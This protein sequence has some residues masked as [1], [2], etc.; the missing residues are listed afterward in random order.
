MRS[1]E[2]K[3]NK[4]LWFLLVIV[5]PLLFAASLTVIIFSLLGVNLID[6]GKNYAANVP[7]I[8]EWVEPTDVKERSREE[9][10]LTLESQVK[11]LQAKN[12]KAETEVLKQEEVIKQQQSDI[13]RLKNQLQDKESEQADQKSSLDRLSEVYSAMPAGNAAQIFETMGKSEAAIILTNL[14]TDAQAAI[15]AEMD[16]ATA[17]ELTK[18]LTNG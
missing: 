17:A 10:I 11:T 13:A 14:E 1:L 9:M 6:K 7:I 15:L 12:E 18:L 2:K 4:A 8:S 16:P 5:I 3:P